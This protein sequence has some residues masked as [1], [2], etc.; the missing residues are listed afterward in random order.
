MVAADVTRAQARVQSA[1]ARV[2]QADRALR[3]RHHHLQRDLRGAAAD[4]PLRQRPGP[5]QPAAGGGLRPPAPYVAFDEY[6]TTVAE[7]NRAQFELFHALGYP[8]RELRRALRTPGEVLPVDTARPG[9][10]APGG[11]RAAP[12][13]PLTP[14]RRPGSADRIRTRRDARRASSMHERPNQKFRPALERLEAKRPLSAARRRPS[15]PQRRS[16]AVTRGGPP[17]EDCGPHSRRLGRRRSRKPITA[18]SCTGSRTRTGSTTQ[19][20]PPFGHVLV[21][22]RQPVPGQVYN[23]LYV[24]REERDD[25]DLQR[26]QRV[27]RSGSPDSPSPSRS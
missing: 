9:L 2:V 22:T 4:H 16:A 20:T 15:R 27:R 13:H 3:H 6:F 19:L 8:A 14:G 12:G 7:Y 17:A 18:T 25:P 24:S 21:Q 10:P 26:E 5:G 11:Q 23:V 1:A